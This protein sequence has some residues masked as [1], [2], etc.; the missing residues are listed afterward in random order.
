VIDVND[1]PPVFI[2]TPYT[3]TVVEDSSGKQL[4]INMMQY[5][6]ISLVS[7]LQIKNEM[8][9]DNCMQGNA[10][11]TILWG[12]DIVFVAINKV[13]LANLHIYI[14]KW[15]LWD[16]MCNRKAPLPKVI[17]TVVGS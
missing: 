1:E 12:G 7:V 4:K 2:N 15:Q 8:V 3:A 9:Q 13:Q 16:G 6:V 17:G 10:Q 5:Q 14:I 11:L